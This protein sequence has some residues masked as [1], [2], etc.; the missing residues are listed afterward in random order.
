[1]D[2]GYGDVFFLL[3][4]NALKRLQ[5]ITSTYSL[6]RKKKC[7]RCMEIIERDPNLLHYKKCKYMLKKT[8]NYFY[9]PYWEQQRNVIIN[10]IKRKVE[11][12]D[13]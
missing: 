4:S 3:H 7:Y 6:L 2:V 12:D 10:S 5:H 9:I 13:F 8:L 1:M 11:G